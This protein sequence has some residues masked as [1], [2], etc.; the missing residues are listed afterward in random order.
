MEEDKSKLYDSADY[1]DCRLGNS[2]EE[3]KK[4]NKKDKIIQKLYTLTVFVILLSLSLLFIATTIKDRTNYKNQAINDV[5]NRWAMAQI[6]SPPLLTLKKEKNVNLNVVEQKYDIT[7]ETSTQKENIFEVPVYIANVKNEG[8]FN[9]AGRKNIEGT[10][11]FSVKDFKGFI[12][13]PK[14]K[15]NGQEIHP[16]NEGKFNLCI[17]TNDDLLKY[18]TEYRL[19]GTRQIEVDTS[20]I[21]TYLK[22]SANYPSLDF[23]GSYSPFDTQYQANSFTGEWS[24]SK[25][26]ATSV[27]K[28][29]DSKLGVAF[30]NSVDNYRMV[31]R[32]LKYGFLFIAL[33][34]LTFF[35]F[36]IKNIEYK[37]H[38]LQ[39]VLIGAS[40]VIFYLLLLSMSEFYNFSV[41]YLIAVIMTILIIG[42]YSYFVITK[43]QDKKFPVLVS[44]FLTIIYL[45]LYMTL[46][47]EQYALL[48]GS[49]GLFFAILITMYATRN[50]QWYE[51]DKTE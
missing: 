15:I 33:T 32:C 22:L 48:F 19:K 18:E 3:N 41:S 5:A 20:N 11:V 42:G 35:V 6:I 45:Y 1:I 40:L 2:M 25:I 4:N 8:Y 50:I 38:P 37:I 26:A 51:N 24:V 14:L 28:E 34:F 49:F 39:Y 36:E 7:V 47:M 44:L 12:E 16:D 10:F 31:E 17:N 43:K 9:L 23:I 21:A 13:T 29:N 27:G 46:N 30:S